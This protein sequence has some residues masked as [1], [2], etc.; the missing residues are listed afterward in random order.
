M[1]RPLLV[2]VKSIGDDVVIAI[3]SWHCRLHF[4]T[5]VL[6][7]CWL[8]ECA[9]EAKAWSGNTSFKLR[10]VGTLHD[11][12]NP[13]WISAGQP[14][15]PSRVFRVNRDLL[16][17]ERIAVRSAG[18]TV[19]MKASAAEASLP[20]EAALQ[21]SQW[22]RVRAKESQARAGDVTRHWSEIKKEHEVQHGPGVTRG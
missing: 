12:S 16:K 22:I 2:D 3:G 10:G 5:A 7:A 15:D 18:A 1:Y 8:D 17:K 21:I 20:Y 19:V 6:L 14:N 9:R 13:N 4:E 11:A